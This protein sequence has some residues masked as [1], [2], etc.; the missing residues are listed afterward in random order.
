MAVEYGEHRGYSLSCT[1]VFQFLFCIVY[2][3]TFLLGFFH[4][5][6]AMIETMVAGMA[7]IYK[8]LTNHPLSCAQT[9]I[10]RYSLLLMC[11]GHNNKEVIC[12]F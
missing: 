2:L 4:L 7:L 6:P 12:L 1:K 9:F 10:P 11:S 8:Q 3:F 5:F